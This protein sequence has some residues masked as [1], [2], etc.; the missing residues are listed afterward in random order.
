MWC[1]TIVQVQMQ[2]GDVVEATNDLSEGRIQMGTRGV[3]ESFDSDGDPNIRFTT[4]QTE[5]FPM[6]VYLVSRAALDR[7]QDRRTP[8]TSQAG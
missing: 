5:S 3:V 1:N 8:Y 6:Q 4:V 2:V 7:T